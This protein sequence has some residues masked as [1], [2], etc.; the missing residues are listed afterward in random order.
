MPR[1]PWAKIREA[2]AS[3][4]RAALPLQIRKVAGERIA[5]LGIHIDGV[6]GDAGL[7]LLPEAAAQKLK[8]REANNIGDWPISTDWDATEDHSRAFAEHWEEWGKW[9]SDHVD[10]FND[11]EGDKVL[12]GLL[13]VACEA[14][15]SLE[16][17]GLLESIP[18]TKDFRVIIA[19][20]DEPN[21]LA[22]RRYELFLKKG[23]IRC[24]EDQ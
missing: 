22:V 17:G 5:G 10:D 3:A 7:Y 24:H 12:R 14:I 4:I 21:D 9:F 11:E 16:S 8:P 1:V 2:L 15:K 6:Y 23:I 20:H 19:E 18:R 13:R